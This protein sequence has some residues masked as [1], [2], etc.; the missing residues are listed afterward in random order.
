MTSF[1]QLEVVDEA[2]A[3]DVDFGLFVSWSPGKPNEEGNKVY[4]LKNIFVTHSTICGNVNAFKS[5]HCSK[6]PDM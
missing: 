1:N 5:Y 4:I 2:V 3:I 6:V